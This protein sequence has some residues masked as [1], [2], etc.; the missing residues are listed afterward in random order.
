MYPIIGL[1]MAHGTAEL[2]QRPMFGYWLGFPTLLAFVE[3]SVRILLGFHRDP[4]TL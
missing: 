1:L 3:R 2:L 4:V